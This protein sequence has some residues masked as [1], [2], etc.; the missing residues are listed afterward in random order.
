MLFLSIRGWVQRPRCF[1]QTAVKMSLLITWTTC[2]LAVRLICNT[3]VA[4]A[5]PPMQR[6][7]PGKYCSFTTPYLRTCVVT[8]AFQSSCLG[9]TGVMG[10]KGGHEK[11]SLVT[12]MRTYTAEG[13]EVALADNHVLCL[14]KYANQSQISANLAKTLKLPPSVCSLVL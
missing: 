12:I 14:S 2:L 6:V 5:Q 9:K 4:Y 7:S 3:R 13:R 8:E 1:W 11:Q 10:R